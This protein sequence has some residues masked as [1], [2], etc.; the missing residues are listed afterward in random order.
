MDGLTYTDAF[1]GLIFASAFIWAP[2]FAF[3]YCRRPFGGSYRNYALAFA[4]TWFATV[5]FFVLMSVWESR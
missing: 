1:I 4:G 2:V 5:A 3:A